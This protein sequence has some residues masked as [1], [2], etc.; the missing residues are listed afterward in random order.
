MHVHA[1]KCI[2]IWCNPQRVFSGAVNNVSSLE[3]RAFHTK[4]IEIKVRVT[5]TN[6]QGI[7]IPY[8]KWISLGELA[9]H[10]F[11]PKW[12]NDLP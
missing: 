6:L 5:F 7:F 4:W 9:F 11:Q 10:S 8:L 1:V 3:L 2:L 12:R